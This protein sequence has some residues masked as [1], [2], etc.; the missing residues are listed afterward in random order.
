MLLVPIKKRFAVDIS[1]IIY[2]M[3]KISM[4]LKYQYVL[5]HGILIFC[6]LLFFQEYRKLKKEIEGLRTLLAVKESKGKFWDFWQAFLCIRC[7]YD[8]GTEFKSQ[9]CG[10]QLKCLSIFHF[11]YALFQ[12]LDATDVLSGNST[13]ESTQTKKFKHRSKVGKFLKSISKTKT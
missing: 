10:L 12:I 7:N 6:V 3:K 9:N 2:V 13:S 8:L 11:K 4:V 5:V 1:L